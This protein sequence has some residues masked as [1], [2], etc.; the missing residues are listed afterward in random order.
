MDMKTITVKAA[1]LDGIL[2]KHLNNSHYAGAHG[3][4]F[5]GKERAEKCKAEII[6]ASVSMRR[7]A[8]A[9]AVSESER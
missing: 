4:P 5:R 1:G 8:R 9:V 7:G 2:Y 3:L 6:E